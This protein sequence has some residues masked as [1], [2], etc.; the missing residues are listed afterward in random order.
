MKKDSR[1]NMVKVAAIQMSHQSSVENNIIKT[2]KKIREAAADGSKIILL[3]ELFDSHYFCKIQE[4]DHFG[5]AHPWDD[6]PLK[7]IL[8]SLA[9]ELE[10]VLPISFYE[11]KGNAYYNSIAVIDADG[12]TLGIYRKSHIPQGPGYEEKFYFSPGD[13]GFKVWN[14][15]YARI[16]VA[17]CWDQWFPEAARIMTLMGAELLFY[18][19][20]IGSEPNN[21]DL[22][23]RDHWMTVQRGHSG[24]NMIPVIAAN[25]VGTEK[26]GDVEL[27]FY[28]SS[29]ITDHRGNL[30]SNADRE[31]ESIITAEFDLQ[32]IERERA[33]WGL[34]RDR[35]PDLYKRIGEL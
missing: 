20:A 6:H 7:S 8:E 22:D 13:T 31:S 15:R 24:A 11:I 21:P 9:K 23:S 5:L 3:S 27:T 34:F 10:V 32:L 25:R 4:G 30:I 1:E 29:F 17:I 19:T 2:E 12:S 16:G 14:T 26:Q 33:E 28:G 35:R 18:P